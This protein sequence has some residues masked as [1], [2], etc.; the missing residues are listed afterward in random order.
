MKESEIAKLLSYILLKCMSL[1]FIGSFL[2]KI[3]ITKKIATKVILQ[4]V[5]LKDL[6]L[7]ILNC[8]FSLSFPLK[9]FSY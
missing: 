1:G 4:S 8:L 2:K 9:V 3:V 6:T 5:S 7:T